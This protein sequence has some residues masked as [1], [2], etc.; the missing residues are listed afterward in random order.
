[1]T[2]AHL[3]TFAALGSAGLLAGAFMFQMLGYAP[4]QMCIWQRYPHVV[5]VALGLVALRL[6]S[7][8]VV[9]L[10]AM[11]AFAS[12]ATG[13]FHAGVEQGWWQG[14]TTCSSGPV[15]D[16]SAEALLD[17]ILAA[18]LVRCDDIAWE[19]IGISMA[20]WNAILS[21]ALV[22]VWIMALKRS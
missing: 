22:A 18:P 11:A 3:I 6:R 10:G 1:M 4:C 9:V 16:L 17:Q 12:G 5:A 7:T 21:F 20:G 19:F 15:S 13:V 14:P 2:R 8:A